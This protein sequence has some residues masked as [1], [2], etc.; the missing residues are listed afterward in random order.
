MPHR[1][2][3]CP[4]RR[5]NLY[6]EQ[7]SDLAEITRDS[8]AQSRVQ[9]HIPEHTENGSHIQQMADHRT[10]PRQ[11]QLLAP[12]PHIQPP[13]D[14]TDIFCTHAKRLTPTTDNESRSGALLKQRP[15]HA[16]RL[17]GNPKITT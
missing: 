14:S 8:L 11:P 10:R 12:Q 13:P 15:V 16:D 7:Q 3:H 4:E 6:L 2:L 1:P 17:T 9:Q 5:W